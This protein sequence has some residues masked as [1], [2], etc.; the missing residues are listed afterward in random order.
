[1][2]TRQSGFTLIEI[3]VAFVMLALVLGVSYEVFSTGLRRAGDLEDYSRALA[4]AQTQ[5]AM[6]SVGDSFEEGQTSGDSEDRRFRWTTTISPYAT[7]ADPAKQALAA[8][9]PVRVA[10]RVTWRSGTEQERHVD[11][12]TLVVGRT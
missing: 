9:Y 6:S 3:V 8:Y 12:A 5:L 10:V 4:I 7:N 2:K 11:L 1:L